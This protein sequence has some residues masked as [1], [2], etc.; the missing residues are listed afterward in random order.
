MVWIWL[1]T[2]IPQAFITINGMFQV[3]WNSAKNRTVT[4]EDHV[5]GSTEDSFL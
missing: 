4:T 3:F 1:L 2:R 5:T